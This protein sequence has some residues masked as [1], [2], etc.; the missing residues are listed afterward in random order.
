ML[1]ALR[2][3]LKLKLAFSILTFLLLFSMPWLYHHN[4]PY[5]DDQGRI[6]TIVHPVGYTALSRSTG[7]GSLEHGTAMDHANDTRLAC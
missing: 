3:C 1:F 6:V 4:L 2:G 7:T 5:A